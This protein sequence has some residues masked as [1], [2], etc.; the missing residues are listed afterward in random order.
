[1]PFEMLLGTIN[2]VEV[3]GWMHQQLQ[4]S[5]QESSTL[6]HSIEK[7]ANRTVCALCVLPGSSV[8]TAMRWTDSFFERDFML[9]NGPL[10]LD[11]KV[12]VKDDADESANPW[13]L[14]KHPSKHGKASLEDGP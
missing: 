4:I 7:E 12:I 6:V 3:D 10:L 13:M 2:G 14:G 9:V 5:I 1:M 8:T 11:V